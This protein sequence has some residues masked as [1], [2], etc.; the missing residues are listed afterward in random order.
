MPTTQ[1]LDSYL[2]H[3]EAGQGRPVVFLHGNP[4]SSHL[5]R[6]VIPHVADQARCIAPDLIGMGASGKPDIPYRFADHATYLDAWFDRLGL[7][8]VVLVGHD[9]GGALAMDWAARHPERVRG[10]ALLETFLRPMTWAEYP[11]RAVDFFRTLRTAGAGERM[12]LD[13]NWFIETGLRATSPGISDADLDI[14]RAP[15]PDRAARR[16]LLQWP[17]E[18]PLDGAPADVAAR[19]TAY[20]DWLAASV[21]TPKLLLTAQPGNLVG[22]AMVD[23][24]RANIA[25]LS[26]V[27]VGPAGHHAPEDQPDAIGQAIA[28]WLRKLEER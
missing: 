2:A 11:P 14:Y 18:I 25:A 5:W 20:D 26:V 28:D 10:I 7:D 13:D 17:R 19:F 27:P 21:D 4:T 1:V 6:N 24:A 16:P 23:W 9:W 3:T 8:N 22:P 15:Y 12:A